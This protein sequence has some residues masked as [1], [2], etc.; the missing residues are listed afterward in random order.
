MLVIGHRGAPNL[1]KENTI[2]SFIKAFDNG[3]DGIEFD[4]QL[5]LDKK[6]VVFHDFDTRA[7]NCKKTLIK[8]LNLAS[9]QNMTS[10]FAIPTLEEVFK[11]IPKDK[12]IHIEIKSQQINN[13][14]IIDLISDLISKYNFR[15]QIIISSFNPFI[16]KEVKEMMPNQRIGALWSTSKN[17]PWFVTHKICKIIK[18]HS[19]HANIKYFDK[20]MAHWV[21]EKNLKLYF[22]TVN[23]E[24]DL[25][26]AIF[27][28]G[29]AIF[30]DNPQILLKFNY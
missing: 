20:F 3:V 14:F 28:K 4:V 6:V 2:D 21:K 30:S 10:S 5:T 18:P 19:F 1:S 9:L 15:K 27:Y 13:S 23:N 26:K 25:K 8:N 16:L 24:E 29:D 11:I 17:T 22:Y 7:L 12:E